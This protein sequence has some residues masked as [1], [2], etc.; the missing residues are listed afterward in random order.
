MR[1][2]LMS[3]FSLLVHVA[4]ALSLGCGSSAVEPR[5]TTSTHGAG[6]AAAAG[7]GTS[8]QRVVIEKM[9]DGSTKKTTITTTRRVV[10]APS[11]PARPADAY[12]AD[13]RVRYNVERVN[14]YRATK[15]LEPVLYDAKISAFARNGSERLSKDHVAHAHFMANA[16]GHPAFGPR[17]AEN[18]GDPNGVPSLDADA[19]TNGRKQIDIMLKLMFD[20]GPGGGH[21]DNMMNPR[22]RRIGVGLVDAGGKMYM[23]NDFSD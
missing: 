7:D 4:L 16:K 1:Q 14:A 2:R 17:N 9:P 22:Y 13:P 5:R 18:Q 21:Y 23:T 11:P 3:R 15:G 8:E 10:E 12:P 20:E 6:S 19:T